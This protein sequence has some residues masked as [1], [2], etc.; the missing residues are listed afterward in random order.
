MT[1][2]I[3]SLMLALSIVISVGSFSAFAEDTEATVDES[4][5]AVADAITAEMLTQDNE[6]A[7][8]L[9][10]NLDM[11]LDGDITLPEG[12]SVAFL[13]SDTSLIANDGTVRRTSAYDGDAKVIAT[14]SKEGS[15]SVTK[16]LSFTVL[17]TEKTVYYSENF[18]SPE[19]ADKEI[20][21]YNSVSAKN[22]SSFLDWNYSNTRT[23]FSSNVS[24]KLISDVDGYA[25]DYKRVN[26]E[27]GSQFDLVKPLDIST[28]ADVVTFSATMNLV[29]WGSGTPRIDMYLFGT[30]TDGNNKK[31][32]E[33]RMSTDRFY[34]FNPTGQPTD[35]TKSTACTTAN[36]GRG[37]NKT[38][39]IEIN[40]RTNTYKVY[41]NG[42]QV[43]V[44]HNLPEYDLS[45]KLKSLQIGMIRHNLSPA[46]FKIKDIAVYSEKASGLRYEDFT[47][48]A[49]SAITKSL[50][51][52]TIFN[53]KAVVWE[54]SKP[55]VIAPDGTVTRN[56]ENNEVILTS[57]IDGE[58]DKTFKFNVLSNRV[59]TSYW[60]SSENF[61]RA[62]AF[63]SIWGTGNGG[64]NG[65]EIDGV[66]DA[67]LTFNH[68]VVDKGEDGASRVLYLHRANEDQT[69]RCYGL[70]PKYKAVDGS[71]SNGLITVSADLCFDFEEGQTPSYI[72]DFW[73]RGNGGGAT[74]VKFD[75][76]A[77][78]LTINTYDY[79]VKLPESG[80][81]FNI[82]VVIDTKRELMEVF[83]DGK[84]VLGY[85][86]E[87]TN[88]C[89][90]DYYGTSLPSGKV[91][92]FSGIF[93]NCNTA[94][95]GMYMDNLALYTIND[96]L[97]KSDVAEYGFYNRKEPVGDYDFSLAI[98]GDIQKT[99]YYWPEKLPK[100]YNW[101]AE[102]AEAKNIARVISLGDI[103]DKD[104]KEEYDVVKDAFSV[105]DGVV[106]HSIIR[107]NHDV[108]NFDKYISYEE[109]KDTIDGSYDESMKNTYTLFEA[110]GRKYMLLNLDCGA[111]DPMLEWAN[112]V[113]AAHPD[114]NVIVATHLYMREDRQLIPHWYG[115][116]NYGQ[117]SGVE[118]WENFVKHHKNIVM[119]LC[120]HIAADT[121]VMNERVGVNGNV[122][123]EFL[124]NQQTN[125]TTYEGSGLVTMFY[126]SEDGKN[127][128]VETYSTTYEAFYRKDNQFEF[129][130]EV[131]AP[132]ELSM[133]VTDFSQNSLE[134]SI[135]ITMSDDAD[136]AVLV[137]VYNENHKLVGVKRCQAQSV[138]NAEL[139]TLD[140][141]KYVKVFCVDSLTMNPECANASVEIK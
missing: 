83:I 126:F 73:E 121:V 4:V 86:T 89:S 8:L 141:V 112:E 124:I 63:K 85:E 62:N 108:A 60:L 17:K 129:E 66:K 29:S 28:D 34:L 18:Y 74:L 40:Y 6:P 33:I 71:Y 11:S 80:Q 47:D 94:D 138:I 20:V 45:V 9:T 16:E 125:D 76:L 52:P 140:T 7:H 131:V 137:A 87:M 77:E 116:D 51:L 111:K 130:V 68:V 99:T 91:P 127:I 110:G 133:E 38:I 109:Y 123:K 55:E 48:E 106:P 122:I 107:G 25:I 32:V 93:F 35:F 95:T 2:K 14:V 103:T 49:P 57:K 119:L 64:G 56:A 15:A 31:I 46:E 42:A 12:V 84:S 81:W 97:Y 23:N 132:K 96:E 136:G 75:Y 69:K 114:Y 44:E 61:E 39:E 113:V 120:G 92:G 139:D 100:T 105:L 118:I 59:S 26:T 67:D 22:E 135:T 41:S 36:I 78:A 27:V 58:A 104:T 98:V 115:V 1:K 102:N 21:N 30:D 53:G 70:S 79:A 65:V 24:T 50:N 82:K 13:S 134:A 37:V 3:L 90:H 117:N 54:S 10:K 72:V 88:T 101:I 19:N 5:Q 128:Q 43:G